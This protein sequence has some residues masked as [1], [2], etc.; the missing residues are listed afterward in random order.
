MLLGASFISLYWGV[1]GVDSS[2]HGFSW[3]LLASVGFASFIFGVAGS[4]MSWKRKRQAAVLFVISL[5]LVA[6]VAAVKA[7]LDSYLLPMP[8]IFLGLSFAVSLINGL[9]IG[10]SD[11]QF[12]TKQAKPQQPKRTQKHTLSG[13]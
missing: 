4:V 8:W 7:S 5:S 1:V 10:N 13:S 6:N 3:V 11:D 2:L 12:P 9:L